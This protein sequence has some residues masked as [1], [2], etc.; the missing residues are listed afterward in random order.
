MPEIHMRARVVACVGVMDPRL[1][2]LL[3]TVRPC[4]EELEGA[5]EFPHGR[6]RGSLYAIDQCIYHMPVGQMS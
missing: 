5:V 2:C 1:R 3:C 4:S 6:G